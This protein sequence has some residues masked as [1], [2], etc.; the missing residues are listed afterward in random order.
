MLQI[1]HSFH[2]LTFELERRQ[3]ITVPL[4]CPKTCLLFDPNKEIKRQI[5]QQKRLINN[6]KQSTSCSILIFNFKLSSSSYSFFFSHSNKNPATLFFIILKFKSF[7]S[8]IAFYH[9]RS[10]EFHNQKR[11]KKKSTIDQFLSSLLFSTKLL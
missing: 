6:Q 3:S 4:T 10:L 8:S 9:W 11:K 2:F 1:S 5:H 7:D